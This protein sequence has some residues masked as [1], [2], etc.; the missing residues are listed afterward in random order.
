MW[1][2]ARRF[3]RQSPIS[4]LA[5]ESLA[6]VQCIL[7]CVEYNLCLES[8]WSETRRTL[9]KGNE[10]TTRSLVE[11]VDFSVSAA[12]QSWGRGKVGVCVC[13]EGMQV[14]FSLLNPP[15]VPIFVSLQCA[16][17][18]SLSLSLSLIAEPLV[19]HLRKF[20]DTGGEAGLEKK[21]LFIWLR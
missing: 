9:K 20:L 6:L 15:H 7:G 12:S 3:G 21:H 8:L 19:L 4:P 13:D 18:P 10:S 2:R 14:Y 11:Q 5:A 16:P 1:G 17:P